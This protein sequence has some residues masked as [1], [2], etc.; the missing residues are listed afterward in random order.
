M[1]KPLF[2]RSTRKY[3]RS[4]KAQIRREVFDTAKRQEM[5]KKLLER[6][7]PKQKE[8]QLDPGR[9]TTPRK[10]LLG[11]RARERQAVVSRPKK[12]K[13]ELVAVVKEK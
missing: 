7:L 11:A 6:F 9:S 12:R 8:E 5:I 3:I 2:P 13:E 4:Q 1:A 10:G